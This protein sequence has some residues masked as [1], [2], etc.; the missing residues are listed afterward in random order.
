MLRL[1]VSLGSHRRPSCLQTRGISG[2][3]N[4]EYILFPLH[5]S[6]LGTLQERKEKG[7]TQAALSRALLV[8][9]WYRICLPVRGTREMQP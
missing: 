1:G 6:Q 5:V 7:L 9:Q 3:S 8:A 4:S 2:F